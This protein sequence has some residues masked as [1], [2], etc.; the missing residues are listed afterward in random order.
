MT[1]AI[2]KA[3]QKLKKMDTD[4][5]TN[6]LNVKIDSRGIRH[7]VVYEQ[8]NDQGGGSTLVKEGHGEESL[9]DWINAMNL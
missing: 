5:H 6:V 7:W 9:S 1:D 4:W 2:Y 8:L 3:Q